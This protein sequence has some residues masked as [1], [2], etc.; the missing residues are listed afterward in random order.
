MDQPQDLKISLFVWEFTPT[1][2]GKG[3]VDGVGGNVKSTACH[4][5]MSKDKN[6]IIQDCESFANTAR[7]LIKSTK[8]VHID[9]AAIIAYN[10]TN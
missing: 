4:C 5:V 8:I 7:N 9:E 10:Q 1:S 6:P 3:V 2:H